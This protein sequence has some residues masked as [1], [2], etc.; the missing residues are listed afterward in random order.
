MSAPLRSLVADPQFRR[1]VADMAPFAPGIA[2][3][4]IVTGVAMVQSGLDVPLALLMS[5]T[6]FAGT[7]Q[8]AAL[9]ILAAGAPLWVLWATAFCVNLRFV[10]FS[11]QW[12][13]YLEH[14]PRGR[15]VLL[16]YFLA[17]LNLLVFQKAWPKGV[18][19]PGQVAYAIGGATIWAVWQI[20]SIVGICAAS[21][22]PV[23]WGLGFAGTLSMLGLV[24]G[25]LV[26]R[27]AQLAAVVAAAAAIAAAA[28]P[29]KLN[30]LVAI[31]A[32]V[33]AGE[34]MDRTQRAARRTPG[35]A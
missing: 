5:L 17:D 10:I 25:L 34:L 12:R 11:A 14:L 35:P 6:V 15:R 18:A 27:K 24:Y 16:G 13:V 33:A 28:L 21:L 20:A 2:A 7:A 23:H 8:L 4:G 3:W 1:G 22:V 26:D 30:I 31:A 32:A 19:E 29:L 9:P